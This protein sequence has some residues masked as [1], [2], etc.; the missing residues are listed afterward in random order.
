MEPASPPPAGPGRTVVLGLGNPVLRDDGVGLVVAAAVLRLLEQTPVQ[1]VDVLASTRAGFELLDLL[2]GYRRAI[3]IDCLTRPDPVPGR[4]HR[5]SL[6]DVAGSARLVN[7]HDLSVGNAFGLA[8]RLGI[9]MPQEVDIVAVEGGDTQTFAEGL[10]PDVAAAVGPLAA[11][12]H[13]DL[14]RRTP[15]GPVPDDPDFARRRTLFRPE[16]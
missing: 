12:I 8:D 2:R 13:A 10:T 4:V 11:A 7:A 1:G 5:L 14:L 3:L 15:E 9:P 16:M 6:D